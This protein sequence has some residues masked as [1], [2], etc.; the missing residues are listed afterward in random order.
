MNEIL[1]LL[2]FGVLLVA[3]VLGLSCI[4]MAVISTKSGKEAMQERIEYGFMGVAG[5]VVVLL[6]AYALS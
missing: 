3:L 2:K 5:L 1:D 6:M 4:V